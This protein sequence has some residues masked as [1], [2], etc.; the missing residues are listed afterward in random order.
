MVLATLHLLTKKEKNLQFHMQDDRSVLI[1]PLPLYL[2]S[3]TTEE[4]NIEMMVGLVKTIASKDFTEE[5]EGLDIHSRPRI[6]DAEPPY[7]Q[8]TFVLAKN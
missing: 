8:K 3:T 4:E 7:N 5:L 2:P 6:T 1:S